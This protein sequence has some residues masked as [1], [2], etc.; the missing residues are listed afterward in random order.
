PFGDGPGDEQVENHHNQHESHEQWDRAKA[1]RLQPVAHLHRHDGCDMGVCEKRDELTD[2]EQLEDQPAESDCGFF[3]RHDH[4]C[5]VAHRP[6]AKSICR[7]DHKTYQ[8]Y[9]HD[10]PIH[11]RRVTHEGAGRS[12]TK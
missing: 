1:D 10:E 4:V 6:C 3:H 11:E 7:T 8:S 9:E 12:V 2:E 5:S